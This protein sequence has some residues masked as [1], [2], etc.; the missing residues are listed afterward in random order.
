MTL[1]MCEEAAMAPIA[2]QAARRGPEARQAQ[3][4][5]KPLDPD[6][7]SASIPAFFIGRNTAGL[8][9]AR[10]ANGRIGGL[11]CSRARRSISAN[12]QS[13]PARCALVFPT[14]TFGL[15]IENRGNP[16]IVLATRLLE[17]AKRLAA[18]VA[19]RRLT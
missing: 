6:V 10:D 2:L 1:Q 8:W 3:V 16:L 9:I 5:L 11:S 18:L 19:A 15:D 4:L 17:G 12:R 13:K 14:G 7:V